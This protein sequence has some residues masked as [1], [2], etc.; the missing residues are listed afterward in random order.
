MSSSQFLIV[1]TT[2]LL[3]LNAAGGRDAILQLLN[4]GFDD[5][6]ARIGFLS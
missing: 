4:T 5:R 2:T 1:D 6:V 3:N